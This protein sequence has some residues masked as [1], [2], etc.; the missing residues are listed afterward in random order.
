VRKLDELIAALTLLTRLPVSGLVGHRNWPEEGAS[1]WAYPLVGA[2]VGSVGGGVLW[3]TQRLG[4][5]PGAAAILALAAM[6]WLTGGL[7]ED[8]LADTADG[9]GSGRTA[10]RKLDIMRDSRIGAYGALA[11]I[12]AVSLRGT[13]LASLPA[14]AGAAA[15]VASG[16]LGRGAIVVVVALLRPARAEGSAAALRHVRPGA[17]ATGLLLAL[18]AASPLPANA[19]MA[20]IVGAGLAA[21]GT[22]ALARQQVGGYTGDIL[23]AGAVLAECAV[24]TIAASSRF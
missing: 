7:H 3:A 13:L 1:V 15:L 17:T 2:L 23:G 9:F 20:C 6:L 18:A 16:G 10:G 8:G 14:P 19:V 5:P 12:V 4:T 11:L 22:A 24:L 21:L